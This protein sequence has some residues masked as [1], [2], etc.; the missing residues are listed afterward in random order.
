MEENT[1]APEQTTGPVE[2]LAIQAKVHEFL[3]SEDVELLPEE[4]ARYTNLIDKYLNGDLVAKREKMIAAN[5][6]KKLVQWYTT[7]YVGQT[8]PEEEAEISEETEEPSKKKKQQYTNVARISTEGL[9]V[10]MEDP[11]GLH[12]LTGV[13]V[14]LYGDHNILRLLVQR[15]E[16]LEAEEGA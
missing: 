6:Y 15:L 5:Q 12:L 14:E 11:A 13:R 4:L 7:E 10:L 16:E 2:E 3:T 1:I 9:A 8:E